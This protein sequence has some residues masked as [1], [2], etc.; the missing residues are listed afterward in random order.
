MK[1]AVRPDPELAYS[2]D[3]PEPV[4]FSSEIISRSIVKWE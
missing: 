2:V 4:H 1:K 3:E